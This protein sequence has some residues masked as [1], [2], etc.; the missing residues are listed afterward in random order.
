VSTSIVASFSSACRAQ[1]YLSVPGA[2]GEIV[3]LEDALGG[4][5]SGNHPVLFIF[6]S[7][8]GAGQWASVGSLLAQLMRSPTSACW[9]CGEKLARGGCFW[10][11]LILIDQLGIQSSVLAVCRLHPEPLPDTPGHPLKDC[12]T[13]L[14]ISFSLN[15]G[16]KRPVGG[17]WNLHEYIGSRAANGRPA[18]C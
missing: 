9:F 6:P 8:I 10:L 14:L 11:T 4:I 1:Q 7:C 18:N 17:A 12:G 5:A 3:P 13:F 2:D 16:I 15:P